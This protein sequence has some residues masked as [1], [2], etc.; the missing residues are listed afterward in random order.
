[1]ILCAGGCGRPVSVMTGVVLLDG[2]PLQNACL[3]FVPI[4]GKGGV[5][6]AHTD[7]EGRYRVGV[8]PTPLRVIV[9]ALKIDGKQANPFDPGGPLVDRFVNALPPEYSQQAETPLVAAPV[10]GQMTTV[11]FAITS[12]AK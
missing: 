12:G 5:S 11:D 4:S 6:F 9:T 7:A 10:E 1:M 8:Y 2:R 3:E